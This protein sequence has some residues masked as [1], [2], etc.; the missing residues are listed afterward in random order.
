MA[1]D[2]VADGRPVLFRNATV[3]T[4]DD[5]HSV[6]TGGDVLVVGDRIAEVGTGSRAPDGALEIDADR[7]H[8]HARHGR[9][10]PAHVADGDARLRRRLDPHPVLRLVLPRARPAV[11]PRGRAH[12]QPALG[13]GRP[14][15]RGHDDRRLVARPAVGRPRR[16]RRRRA[17][18]GARPVRAGLRQ[19]PGRPVGVDGRPRGALVPRAPPRRPLRLAARLRRHGRPG[20]PGAPGLRGGPRARPAGHDAR[21]GLGRDERRRHPAHARERLHERVAAST[22]TP[23]RCRPTPTTASRP[24][25]GRPRCRPSRSRV[26]DRATRPPGSCAG[27]TS[28]CRCRWTPACGGAATC[29][30]RCARPWAPTARASTSRRTPPATP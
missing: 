24:P 20:L 29:S 30:R 23:R 19:H 11:P 5:A 28:R 3:L 9:H 1:H 27:T 18:V 22:C 16:G 2:E 8:R 7:R 12:R 21:R 4:M 6:L 15:G 14:R 25:A 17:P 13:L 10:P 26:P